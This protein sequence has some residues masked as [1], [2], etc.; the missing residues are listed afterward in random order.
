M[1]RFMESSIGVLE[2]VAVSSCGI[3]YEHTFVVVDFG[4]KT[5]FQII[6]GCPIMHQFKMIQDSDY[7]YIYLRQPSVV[8]RID[9]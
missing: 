8:T 7:N 3:E 4:T 2:K 1:D 5:H 9:L 6:L